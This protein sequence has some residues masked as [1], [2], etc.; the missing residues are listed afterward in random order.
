MRIV[1]DLDGVLCTIKQPGESY[2]DVQPIPGAAERLRQFRAAGHTVVIQTARNMATQDGNLGRIMKNVGRVTLEW[3]D[4]H[5]MEYDEIYF[6]KPN[7][8]VYI[9]DRAVRFLDWQDLEL[10]DLLEEAHER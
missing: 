3:L 9:D 7:G 6:G 8:H 10:K 4:R 2:A 5:G 1:I